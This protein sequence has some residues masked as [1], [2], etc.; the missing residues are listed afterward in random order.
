MAVRLVEHTADVAIEA[1]GATREEALAQAALGV[2]MVVTGRSDAHTL[3]PDAEARFWL[4]APDLGAVAVA[5][6]SELLWL[7]ESKDQ[8]WVGGGV[9]LSE[10]P[11]ERTT[12][13]PVQ[14][15]R[16]EARGNMVA[17]DPVVHGRGVE[18]KA[19]T[20]HDLAFAKA[21]GRWHLRVV[22]DL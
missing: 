13:G 12:N 10:G 21:D 11:V 8:L 1:E 17:Y 7:L 20:Y 15:L 4:E 19:V 5:F 9:Q 22:L 6:L 16:L 3:V 14:E 2:A 18:V